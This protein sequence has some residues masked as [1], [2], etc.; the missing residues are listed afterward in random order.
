[1][2]PTSKEEGDHPPR[3]ALGHITA[4][5]AVHEYLERQGI[6]AIEYLERHVRGDWG[7]M[8]ADDVAEN[9]FAVPR[10]L[11]LMSSYMI[12]CKQVWIIT[13][14]DR[15]ATTLLFPFEY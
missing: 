2:K 15:S 12:G 7:D 10:R 6:E 9:E 3:F 11:R 4:T 8:P 14:A 5:L 1:M 13:E